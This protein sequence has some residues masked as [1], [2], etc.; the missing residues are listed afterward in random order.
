MPIWLSHVHLALKFHVLLVFFSSTS[1]VCIHPQ[2]FGSI[3]FSFDNFQK[4]F[5]FDNFQK[6][7]SYMHIEIICDREFYVLNNMQNE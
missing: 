5:S 1:Q 4:V 3:I 7:K 2:V 6:V